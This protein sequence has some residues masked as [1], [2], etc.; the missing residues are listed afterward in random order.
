[1]K[2]VPQKA[3]VAAPEAFKTAMVL[4]L[5]EQAQQGQLHLFF[6][7]AAHFVKL[8]FLGYVYSLTARF[9][10]SSS[11]RQRFN[12]RGALHAVTHELVTVTNHTYLT[13]GS[14]CA[15]L[16]KL[17]AQ[18]QDL[19]LVLVLDNARYQKCR[20]VLE[21]AAR[22]NLQLVYLPP[23]SPNLNLIER[24]WKFVKKKVLYNRFYET[25]PAFHTAISACLSQT[26]TTHRDDL[27]SL[28]RPQFQT[29]ERACS[30]P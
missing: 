5:V 15:L 20:L 29:F 13:A 8:T 7:D 14:V 1:V 24:L 16:E 30:Q 11:G 9:V 21:T 18:F 10:K 17:H 4:P 6:V 26:H 28:L 27:N 22:L 3:D 25:Y 2:A 23:Y 19:P 12:V